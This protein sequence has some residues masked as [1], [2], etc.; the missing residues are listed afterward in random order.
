MVVFAII[1]G[2]L[3]PKLPYITPWHILGSILVVIGAALMCKF[4]PF[5]LKKHLVGPNEELDYRHCRLGNE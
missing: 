2:A 3:M 5:S 4:V 1:N